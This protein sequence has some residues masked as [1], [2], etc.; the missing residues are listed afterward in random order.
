MIISSLPRIYNM[1]FEKSEDL[2]YFAINHLA[3]LFDKFVKTFD[4]S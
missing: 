4:L 1:L 3:K 2:V